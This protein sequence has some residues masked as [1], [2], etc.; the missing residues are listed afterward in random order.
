MTRMWALDD[1]MWE[2]I[3]PLLPVSVGRRGRNFRDHRQV[4]EGILYRLRTSVPWRDLPDCYGPWQTVWKRHNRFSKD[5]TWDRVLAVLHAQAE[6]LGRIDWNVAVDST[7]ARA[8]QHATNIAR[9]ASPLAA[10]TG[11]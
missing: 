11:G 5:G 3:E 1:V 8:H 6:A 10:R 4:I 7:I 2:R 9:S